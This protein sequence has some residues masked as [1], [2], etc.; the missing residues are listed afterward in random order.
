LVVLVVLV[1]FDDT[2]AGEVTGVL[3]ASTG[4]VVALVGT[5]VTLAPRTP[6]AAWLAFAPV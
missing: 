4:S 2:V 5:V 1:V 3:A 6:C